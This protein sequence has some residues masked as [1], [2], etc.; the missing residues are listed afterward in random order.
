MQL[1]VAEIARRLGEAMS[2]IKKV[3]DYNYVII[4]AD[5][6]TAFE[7]LKSVI[8]AERVRRERVMDEVAR[9]FGKFLD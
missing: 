7:Q 5:L 2:E 8:I 4:N 9:L 3:M 6:E 1:S